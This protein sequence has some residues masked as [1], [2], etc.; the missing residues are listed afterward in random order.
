MHDFRAYIFAK[1]H[2]P[3]R[4]LSAI[5]ELLVLRS[6]TPAVYTV[7]PDGG[8]QKEFDNFYCALLSLSDKHYPERSITVTS[9][10]PPTLRLLSKACYG[11]T[12][13]LCGQNTQRKQP[14]LQSRSEQPLSAT[15]V[16][17]SADLTHSTAQQSYGRRCANSRVT[18]IALRVIV[19]QSLLN[20]LMITTPLFQ[21]IAVTQLRR[22]NLN[23]L[24]VTELTMHA[25]H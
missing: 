20:H 22:L 17:N 12:T 7:N 11:R 16:L 9:A 13:S 14:R 8:V 21:Q 3:Q 23:A 24:L 2:P 1:A 15:T 25:H 5:A 6:V 10:D 18:V 19:L 4:G